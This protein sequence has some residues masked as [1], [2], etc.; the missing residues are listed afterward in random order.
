MSNKLFY[1][2]SFTLVFAGWY[3][4][5]NP[6]GDQSEFNAECWQAVQFDS[7]DHLFTRW[8]ML[9]DLITQND[10]DSY[11]KDQLVK[12]LGTPEVQVNGDYRYIL[13]HAKNR[14]GV[15]QLIFTFNDQNIVEQ[16][17]IW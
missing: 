17:T 13:G 2:I 4:I 14:V 10:L 3:L 5:I 11:S 6:L 12:L 9:D 16:V 7:G 1:S 8:E 15:G